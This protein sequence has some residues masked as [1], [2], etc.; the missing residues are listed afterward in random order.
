MEVN[1]NNDI[2]SKILPSKSASIFSASQAP[3]VNSIFSKYDADNDG[4]ITLKDGTTDD[5]S[6]IGKDKNAFSQQF[7]SK[8]TTIGNRIIEDSIITDSNTGEFIS[9]VS[10]HKDKTT[11][12]IIQTKMTTPSDIPGFSNY[13]VKNEKGEITDSVKFSKDE[14]GQHEDINMTTSDGGK[15]IK[16]VTINGNNKSMESTITDKKGNILYQVSKE[17]ERND[18]TACVKVNGE[19]YT[20]EGLD[21]DKFTLTSPD[22]TKQNIDLNKYCAKKLTAKPNPKS[23]KFDT[24]EEQATAE[25]QKKLK[26]AFKNLPPDVMIKCINKAPNG[27]GFMVNFDP[28]GN[29]TKDRD[30]TFDDGRGVLWITKNNDSDLVLHEL[31]HAMDGGDEKVDEN[32]KPYTKFD[33]S[34]NKEF[35]TAF[36]NANSG[37][38]RTETSE[39]ERQYSSHVTDTPKE[40]LADSYSIVQNMDLKQPDV[41]HLVLMKYFAPAIAQGNTL[42]E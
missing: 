11:G 13:Q 18:K 19:I 27:F 41:R 9:Q 35:E 22:G 3:Y 42:L 39:A 6:L 7:N 16:S 2:Q 23:E 8:M 5:P 37:K 26:T 30:G 29:E 24:K 33:I 31:S 20:V 21:T 40:L 1:N 12:Q 32:G 38:F 4:K 28:R 10:I 25:E 14:N 17:Y 15:F 36:K 34:G